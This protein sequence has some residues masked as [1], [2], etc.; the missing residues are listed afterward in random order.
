MLEKLSQNSKLFFC[1]ARVTST[2]YL[3]EK[4]GNKIGDVSEE[5]RDEEC[6]QQNSTAVLLKVRSS[7]NKNEQGEQVTD[8]T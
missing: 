6:R 7:G 3:H 1:P 2:S 4:I 8:A 5:D